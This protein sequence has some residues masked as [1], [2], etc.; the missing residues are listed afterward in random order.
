MREKAIE[1]GV[2]LFGEGGDKAAGA[3]WEKMKVALFGGAEPKPV[4]LAHF[5]EEDLKRAGLMPVFAKAWGKLFSGTTSGL[6]MASS[7]STPE[8]DTSAGF[9][10]KRARKYTG[11]AL[12]TFYASTS[13]DVSL[14]AE[15]DRRTGDDQWVIAV[16]GKVVADQSARFI[17]WLANGDEPPAAVMVGDVKIKP[18]RRGEEKTA[19]KFREDPSAPGKRLPVDLVSK[20]TGCNFTN[21]SDECCQFFRVAL[22]YELKGEGP[23]TK[24]V[25]A[26]E[27]ANKN[28]ADLANKLPDA[29]D[30]YEK[31]RNAKKLPDL[32]ISEETPDAG[33]EP[34]QR[35]VLRDGSPNFPVAGGDRAIPSGRGT[36]P[37]HIPTEEQI[38]VVYDVLMTVPVMP[39]RDALLAGI[40]YA[41][42]QSLPINR[43]PSVQLLTDLNHLRN[44]GQLTDG[45]YPV[46]QY[47]EN[48]IL[49]LAGQKGTERLRACLVPVGG[50]N[51]VV[52]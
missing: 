41:V 7:V 21:V 23:L 40:R 47:I 27:L 28:P 32:F 22:S 31:L 6:T 11:L 25:I 51:P 26:R 36:T 50:S 15:I 38:R 35:R 5:G 30:A 29:F 1:M 43:V 46:R 18:V 13:D 48:A 45:S 24:R 3:E 16:D 39:G 14:N 17:D 37:V 19:K 42:T 49:L 33:C 34:V 12:A 2:E 9:R 52:V 4:A 20:M 44:M 8:E 10:A